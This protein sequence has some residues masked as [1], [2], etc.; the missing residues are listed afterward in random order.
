MP[1]LKKAL[2]VRRESAKLDRDKHY[3]RSLTRVMLCR[4][5]VGIGRWGDGLCRVAYE[6]LYDRICRENRKPLAGGT[7]LRLTE[8]ITFSLLDLYEAVLPQLHVDGV[9]RQ[10]VL[11]VL[12]EELFL[13]TVFIELMKIRQK[14]A[15]IMLDLEINSYLPMMEKMERK[16]PFP[17][18][19]KFWLNSASFRYA[20][21]VGKVTGS[22]SNRK[23]VHEWLRGRHIPGPGA[24]S[25]IVEEFSADA[26]RFDSSGS[27]KARLGLAAAVQ[28][29]S[30]ITD[31]FFKTRMPA[32]SLQF[33][34]ILHAIQEDGV[35]VDDDLFLANPRTFFAARLL[36]RR[37]KRE[38]LWQPKV[39]A[40][41]STGNGGFP[42]ESSDEEIEKG[43]RE[44]VWRANPGNWFLHYVLD[45]IAAN[46]LGDEESLKG[47]ESTQDRIFA[48]GI[49]EINNILDEKRA[50]G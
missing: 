28:E 43:R 6:A 13:P 34:K 27:W 37:L 40:H 20:D 4:A 15:K 2:K 3:P 26:G 24:I 32:S 21:D 1:E 31:S 25:K 11:W 45:E 22:D 48:L 30:Q 10:E 47:A 49:A 18:I 50:G 33:S 44:L 38:K 46:R 8:R 19:L 39:L 17:R 5:E 36:Q 35:A 29:L 42:K 16:D 41:V 7:P 23:K 14:G 12:V 9:S